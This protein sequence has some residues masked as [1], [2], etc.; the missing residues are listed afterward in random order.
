MRDKCLYCGLEIER[1]GG[2]LWYSSSTGSICYENRGRGGHI[3]AEPSLEPEG[4][5]DTSQNSPETWDRPDLDY[6][7]TPGISV[8]RDRESDAQSGNPWYPTDEPQPAAQ[9]EA[10]TVSE[11]QAPGVP[12]G[13]ILKRLD[14]AHYIVAGIHSGKVQVRMCIPTEPDKDT[15]L[16]ACTAI[17]DAKSEIASLREKLEQA[18]RKIAQAQAF[19]H[20]VN[21]LIKRAE[22]DA[23]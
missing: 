12:D 11:M 17:Q 9:S 15:D 20:G 10:A 5:P 22:R 18:E 16:V 8:D 1:G 21:L 19:E 2:G 23:Q 13:D 4:T 3:L 6:R 7:R 14:R